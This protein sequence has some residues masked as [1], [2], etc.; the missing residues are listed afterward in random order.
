MRIK[1]GGRKLGVQNK[2]SAETKEALQA[3]LNKEFANI[4]ELLEQLTPKDKLD[5]LIKMMPY[6]VPKQT[7]VINPES[8]Q[9][10]RPITIL[11]IGNGINPEAEHPNDN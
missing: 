4:P 1:S 8:N 10:V 2:T 7:E 9:T 6:I 11:N 5:A 3:I